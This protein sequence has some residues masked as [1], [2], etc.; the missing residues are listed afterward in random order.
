MDAHISGRA[1][2]R[3]PLWTLMVLQLWLRA[4]AEERF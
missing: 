1:D 3:K 4:R 2:S